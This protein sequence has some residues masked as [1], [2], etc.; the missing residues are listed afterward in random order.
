MESKLISIAK[1]FSRYPAG[2]YATDGP[3]SGETFRE[4]L[5][6]PAFDSGATVIVDLEGARGYGSSFL[7][8]A[9]GGMVRK[10]FAADDVLKRI[11][12]RSEDDSLVQEIREYIQQAR[13][14]K[15]S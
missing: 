14:P 7:E 2:R 8:E 12:F 13:N 11:T 3:Y 9:F 5:L 1:E 15:P 6:I 4:K 10:G